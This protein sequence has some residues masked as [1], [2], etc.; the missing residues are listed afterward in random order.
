MAAS[1]TLRFRVGV[2]LGLLLLGA[3]PSAFSL[4]YAGDVFSLSSWVLTIPL[5]DDG[6]GIA[7]EVIMP[8]LRNF[9]DP[10]FFRLSG[11]A[12][13]IVFR[14]RCDDATPLGTEFPRCQLRELK[15]GT[16]TPAQWGSGDGL[17]HNMTI[18]AAFHGAPEANP[19]V[20]A[21][22][23]YEGEKEI[24]TLLLE[25]R[26]V[27]LSRDGLEPLVLLEEYV[28]GTPFE[29]MVII[30][31]KR[32]RAFFSNVQIAE[33]PLENDNLHYRA[34][35]EVQSTPSLGDGAG[36]YGEVEI[37]ALYITHGSR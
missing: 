37:R 7:D 14:A 35:C 20:V 25:G 33:W 18:T 3:G 28:M 22:G 17:V 32:A 23:V 26:R 16:T 1:L 21:A 30:D 34:G 10:D 24:I 27:L 15:K 12:D 13:S 4:N 29:L 11:T 19:H 6:D 9:E 8:T 31:N 5:D 36:Q 2:Y